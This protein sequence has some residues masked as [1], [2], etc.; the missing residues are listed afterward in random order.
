MRQAGL[1]AAATRLAR[2]LARFAGPRGMLGAGVLMLAGALA[3]GL[4]LAMIVPLVAA[5]ADPLSPRW[6]VLAP[7]CT[8]LG[9]CAPDE[10]LPLVLALFVVAFTLRAVLL[11][12][13]DRVVAGLESGF[14][15]YRRIALVRALAASP[16]DH[17]AELR[18][19][20]ITYLLSAEVLRLSTAVRQLATTTMSATMLAGQWLVLALIAPVLA[21]LFIL[22]AL[23]AVA[24]AM[25][26]W[27]RAGRLAQDNRQGHLA[28][29]NL[30]GQ[31]LGGLKLALAQDLQ[32]AF[33]AEMAQ[34]SQAILQRGEDYERR[35]GRARVLTAAGAA[36]GLALV[37]WLGS[38]QHLTAPALIAAIA[39][40]A[41]MLGP[42][43]AVLRSIKLLATSI[44]AHGEL[45]AMEAELGGSPVEPQGTASTLALLT[46]PLR[47]EQVGFLRPDGA[48]C[49]QALDLT[50]PPGSRIGVTGPSGAGKTTFV[51][52]LCGLLTPQSGQVTVDGHALS[53]SPL[54]RWR[55]GISYV[56]QDSYLF[57]DSLRRNLTWGL[58]HVDDAAIHAAL[59]I[60]EAAEV[61]ERL[62]L[63]LDQ[64][65]G[66]R[67]VRLSGG[68][69]Q[70]LAL[71]RALIRQ[72]RLIVLD[73][74]TNALDLATEARIMQ[75]LAALPGNPTLIVIAHRTETLAMCTRQLRFDGG[76][77]VEDRAVQLSA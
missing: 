7:L 44:P 61:V 47:F 39:V 37:V 42:G 29:A 13:R 33:V 51:D 12:W 11:A 57:N 19:A 27:R 66:E 67:G 75:R 72:P 74:A 5:M 10:R 20:R 69:R 77:L 38:R 24:I 62:P 53:G 21:M 25:P 15:E 31:L 28:I 16:W 48:V 34:A 50:I 46:G 45:L 73:E 56:A 52:L 23:I 4:S 30:A 18:H 6:Q 43:G 3:E 2:D 17:L 68:E 70:R 60:A 9:L 1:I 8:P 32:H 55:A 40:C 63:G 71:A 14:V 76:E 54:H 22:A 36:L 59:A 64:P 49:F 35:A 41:R 65:V 26:G 58:P